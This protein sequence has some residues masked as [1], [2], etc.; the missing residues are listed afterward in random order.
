MNYSNGNF[1]SFYSGLR[2]KHREIRSSEPQPENKGFHRMPT[3][4]MISR[5]LIRDF[6]NVN[7]TDASGLT[8]SRSNTGSDIQLNMS[9]PTARNS[10]NKTEKKYAEVNRT[11]GSSRMGASASPTEYVF[12]TQSVKR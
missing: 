12:G 9:S 2:Q 5:E 4:H 10:I 1:L 3:M 11:P 8:S 7:G 6:S